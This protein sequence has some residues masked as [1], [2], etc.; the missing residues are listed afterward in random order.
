MVMWYSGCVMVVRNVVW[1]DPGFSIAHAEHCSVGVHFGLDITDEILL[2]VIGV[3]KH[4][5]F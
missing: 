5:E 2:M 4:Y 1:V 3:R